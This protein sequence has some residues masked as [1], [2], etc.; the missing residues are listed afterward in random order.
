MKRI[1]L[2]VFVILTAFAYGQNNIGIVSSP[3]KS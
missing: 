1:F 2:S 3:E